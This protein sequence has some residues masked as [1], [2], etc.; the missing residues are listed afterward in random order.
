MARRRT[1]QSARKRKPKT[2]TPVS[3]IQALEGTVEL[4][5]FEELPIHDSTWGLCTGADNDWREDL[6]CETHGLDDEVIGRSLL[7]ERYKYSIY[8]GLGREMYDLLDD[9][10]EL[11]NLIEDPTCDDV[12][13]ELQHR[14]SYWQE[15]T[16]DRQCMFE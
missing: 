11:T 2:E 12:R 14:L 1:A 15:R 4:V 16:R 8:A 7:T 13:A 3:T 10:Y 6:M 5:K 9:P